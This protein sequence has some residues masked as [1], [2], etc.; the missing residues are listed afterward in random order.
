MVECTVLSFDHPGEFSIIAGVLA[1]VGFEIASGDVFTYA[2]PAERADGADQLRRRIIDRFSGMAPADAPWEEWRDEAERRLSLALSLLERGA[3]GADQARRLANEWFARRLARGPAMPLP[4]LYPV[5][6]E[7]CIDDDATRMRVVAQDTP[8]FLYSLS[9]ALALHGVSIERVRI[10]TVGGRVEDELEFVDLSGRPVRDPER[11]DGIRLS[12]LFTKQFTYFLDRAPDPAAALSRFEQMAQEVVRWPEGGRWLEVL[13]SPRAMSDLARL[14]G[15]SDFLWEDFLRLQYESLLPLLTSRNRHLVEPPKTLADRLRASLAGAATYEEARER[16]NEFK[17]REILR[18]DLDHILRPGSPLWRLSERLTAL[19]ECVVREAAGIVHQRLASCHGRPRTVGGIEARWAVAGL[20][21]FGGAALGYASD[22]ELLFL[23]DDQG[24]TDGDRPVENSEFFG[25]MALETARFIRARREGIFH[26][27]L[28]LRPHGTAGPA[29]CSLAEFCRYYGPGGVAHSYERLALTRLRVVA[30]DPEFGARI[31]RLRDEFVYGAREIRLDELRDLRARQFAEKAGAGGVNAKFSPGA[32]VDLEY[33]VQILQ[34][35][36]A[37]EHPALRTPLMHRALEELER[38]GILSA[39][40]GPR[41]RRA[42]DFLRRLINGLRMLRGSARDL[43]LPEAG[44]L[45]F[46]HLARRMGYA[47]RGDLAAEQQLRM[48]FAAH[49]A[50]VRVFVERHLGVGALPGPGEGTMADL[51]LLPDPPESL[52]WRVLRGAG[53]EDVRR[54][55]TNLRR[56]SGTGMWREEFARLAVLAADVLREQPDPD[57][58]LNNWE[59]VFASLPDP[60]GHIH[61]LMSQPR[62]LEVLLGILSRSQ[63][64]A[65]TLHRNPEFFEAATD[66]RDLHRALPPAEMEERWLGRRPP[67]GAPAEAWM[68]ALRLHRRREMLRIGIRDLYLRAPLPDIAAELSALADAL[69]RAALGRAAMEQGLGPEGPTSFCVM[70]L[71]KLGGIELNYSSDVDLLGVFED[72]AEG[73]AGTWARLME[74][75]RALLADHTDEGW[76]YRVDFRLRPHGRAGGLCHGA[77]SL[78][79]YFERDAAGWELQA[80]LKLRPVAGDLAVGGRVRERLM[81]AVSRRADPH[82][83]A[84]EAVRMREMAIREV[85]M[86][87]DPAADLKN[88]A[89]GI[90]DIEF[91]VQVLQIAGLRD[92]PDLAEGNTLGAI[93]RLRLAGAMDATTAETLASDY[94]HFRRIEHALQILDDRRVH[95]LPTDAAE[96]EALAR[97]LA[98]RG[99]SP[100]EFY[101]DLARRM[102]RVRDLFADQVGRL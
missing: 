49:T 81:A 58:A 4:K 43:F 40:E 11:L 75:T 102:H 19:A 92:H 41:L 61:L 10:R 13:S 87:G 94:S 30:G 68:A 100:S 64:L 36:H 47:D 60:A 14:L 89:G 39:D 98:G 32:L 63:F 8:G 101:E 12:V 20:G 72:S 80:L 45:E 28:R 46:V 79:A 25:E 24:R 15:A 66:P 83:V 86:R 23:Y 74:R 59:R 62:R 88:G 65:D 35:L 71:G 42:Y 29:A 5:Q 95:V 18:I 73:D 21:K 50:A 38:A 51:I 78:E 93:E 70:A 96:R 76:V 17:D 44:S 53:V 9:A 1:G 7:L 16:L 90:R 91:L 34:V 85:A 52:R 56:M 33:T 99:V 84:A 54:A 37:C 67:P 55:F 2:R 77:S 97:R 6:I 27:D 31:E 82:A 3:G 48:D 69:I 26:V 57:M 22:I